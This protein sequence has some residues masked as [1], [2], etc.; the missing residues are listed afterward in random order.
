M[1]DF[2]QYS[3]PLFDLVNELR[4]DSEDMQRRIANSLI[5]LIKSPLLYEKQISFFFKK[6]I[7]YKLYGLFAE[8][9]CIP[10]IKEL[11]QL[12]FTVP[13]YLTPLVPTNKQKHYVNIVEAM[14]AFE[15][16]HKETRQLL[17]DIVKK[18]APIISQMFLNRKNIIQHIDVDLPS[19][20]QSSFFLELFNSIKLPVASLTP[21]TYDFIRSSI[22]YMERV[23]LTKLAMCNNSLFHYQATLLL[24]SMCCRAEIYAKSTNEDKVLMKNICSELPD[25]KVILL[26]SQSIL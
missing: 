26:L 15:F 5:M 9:T 13:G 7:L 22:V 18:Q 12:L 6:I 14:L 3:N 25:V 10:E 11:I 16:S 23:Y 21:S 1:N 8:P 4:D 20:I 17:F 24:Y 19:Y 2:I